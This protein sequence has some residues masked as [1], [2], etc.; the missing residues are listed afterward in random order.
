MTKEAIKETYLDK[1]A[2]KMK[3]EWHSQ[4]VHKMA[5]GIWMLDTLDIKDAKKR[6]ELLK[7]WHE[8]PPAFGTN[9]SA[10]GQALGRESAKAKIEKT[11]AGF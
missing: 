7:K 2:E 3:I 9:C 8:T 5:V 10:L 4:A 6:E 11:F 1:V